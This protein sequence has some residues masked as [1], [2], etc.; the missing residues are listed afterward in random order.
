MQRKEG[1]ALHLLKQ[2]CQQQ[3]SDAPVA[4]RARDTM[5]QDDIIKTRTKRSRPHI[6]EDTKVYDGYN[7]RTKLQIPISL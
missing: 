1:T 2:Q 6:K 5:Q 4:G 7:I 3:V